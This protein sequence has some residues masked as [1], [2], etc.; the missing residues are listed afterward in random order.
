MVLFRA[1]IS[2]ECGSG[3]AEATLA[4]SITPAVIGIDIDGAVPV[5]A[6]TSEK[7]ML[8]AEEDPYHVVESQSLRLP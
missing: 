3:L 4:N 8:V 7:Q 5:V 2:S 1:A 6:M